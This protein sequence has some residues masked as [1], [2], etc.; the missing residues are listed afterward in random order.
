M[1]TRKGAKS[2]PRLTWCLYSSQRSIQY[3]A[4][5]LLYERNAKLPQVFHL[6]ARTRCDATHSHLKHG[7]VQHI[8]W[9][10]AASGLARGNAGTCRD[11]EVSQPRGLRWRDWSSGL[12]LNK[13]RLDVDG[14]EGL[15]DAENRIS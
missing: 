11:K 14:L 2:L 1:G 10:S 8:S 4:V 3:M 12:A 7:V 13:E 5:A 6:S 9:T 15:D